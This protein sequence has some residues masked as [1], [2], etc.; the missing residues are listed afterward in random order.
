MKMERKS[1]QTMKLL[2][3]N[4]MK[5]GNIFANILRPLLCGW[6]AKF[7]PAIFVCFRELRLLDQQ[8]SM[9]PALIY[10]YLHK[11]KVRQSKKIRGATE[12]GL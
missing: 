8:F 11:K 1:L 9:L 5:F 12:K 6:I 7:S 10:S 4:K 2:R 3:R